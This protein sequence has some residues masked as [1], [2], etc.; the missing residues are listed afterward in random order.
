MRCVEQVEQVGWVWDK[1]GQGRGGG[2][3]ERLG[4]ISW[5]KV[6][7]TRRDKWDKLEEEAGQVSRKWTGE[8][9]KS[10]GTRW[11]NGKSRTNRSSGTSGMNVI[12]GGIRGT[13]W[14]GGASG[15]NGTSGDGTRGSSGIDWTSRVCG[16]GGT[17]GTSGT[18]A[19][20]HN[21]RDI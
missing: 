3:S 2:S 6:C 21:E 20:R 5:D 19:R 18:Q 4:S 10:S 9:R 14:T 16:T 15:S 8:T 17:S 1:S 11:A 12:T 13:N 7:G